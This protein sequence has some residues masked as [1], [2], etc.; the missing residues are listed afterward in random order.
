MSPPGLTATS[1][2]GGSTAPSNNHELADRA[3][4][5]ALPPA[6]AD[7]PVIEFATRERR[8]SLD[9]PWGHR[10]RELEER[11]VG[12]EG[13][14]IQ[15]RWEFGKTLLDHREGKQLPK[16]LL[17]AV[18]KEHGI[19]RTEI[20]RRMQFA[21]KCTTKD[22]VL[23]ARSTY[24]SWRQIVSKALPKNAASTEPQPSTFEQRMTDRVTRMINEAKT[25]DEKSL[26]AQIL[27][28]AA[29]QLSIAGEPEPSKSKQSEESGRAAAIDVLRAEHGRIVPMTI[30]ELITNMT[31]PDIH[32]AGALAG[33]VTR[34]WGSWAAFEKD[35]R[36]YNTE[37]AQQQTVIAKAIYGSGTA[38]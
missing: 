19:S 11:I 20:W 14:S 10:L 24:S 34:H 7:A 17:A 21:E 33:A 28:D 38:C 6:G 27:L 22:E 5:N 36:T 13:D 23:H 15:A 37:R 30:A 29:Q 26:L 35:R 25:P 12:N 2:N 31:D 1:R 3:A 4:H 32:G 9:S 18:V 8:G 16:G